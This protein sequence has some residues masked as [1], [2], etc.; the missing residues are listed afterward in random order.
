MTKHLEALLRDM[1]GAPA[2]YVWVSVLVA[3]VGLGGYALLMSVIHSLEVFEFTLKIPWAMMVSNYVFLI[4]SSTGLCMVASMGYVFGLERYTMI[5]KRAVFLAVFAILFGM[6]SIML[7]LGHPERA[8]VFTILTPNI[9]SAMWWMGGIYGAYIASLVVWCWLL[10]RRDLVANADDPGLKGTICRWLSLQEAMSTL[11]RRFPKSQGIIGKLSGMLDSE[12]ERSKW[13]R[14][15]ATLS[16]VSGLCAYVVEGS[17]FAHIEARAFWYGPLTP[18]YFLLGAALCGISWVLV[19]GIITYRVR[20]EDLPADLKDLFCEMAEILAL[21]LSVAFLAIVYKMGHGLFVPNKAATVWLFLTGPF[22][23]AFWMLEIAMGLVLPIFVLLFASRKQ[24]MPGIM[25]GAVMVL[26]G[27][28][29]KRYDYVV[30]SQIYPVIKNHLPSYL[31]TFIEVLLI[32]GLLGA[33]LLIYTLGDRF[34]P[35]KEKGYY[36]VS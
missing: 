24:M 21:L 1:D 17:L 35:L 9:R 15:F 22:S 8:A 11:G 25:I 23:L 34:L 3:L 29:M 13:I 12:T 10:L 27:Y 18:I 14:I 36:D 4:G 30:A 31:P 19:T 33:F 5:G 26:A 32:G 20:G 7:H 28:F 6:A 16:L 2:F